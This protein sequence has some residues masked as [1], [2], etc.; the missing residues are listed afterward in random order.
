MFLEVLG[1]NLWRGMYV[2]DWD[3]IF[4]NISKWIMEAAWN[5]PRL[6][7]SISVS[8]FVTMSLHCTSSNICIYTQVKRIRS[9]TV[10]GCNRI[11]R[12]QWKLSCGCAAKIA[13]AP[14][15]WLYIMHHEQSWP[16]QQLIW[17]LACWAGTWRYRPFCP[18]LHFTYPSCTWAKVNKER[19]HKETKPQH[20]PNKN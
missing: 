10:V 15:Y 16:G 13:R 20:R 12:I 5:R 3:I 9:G 19:K 7:P 14:S 1:L 6:L 8:V 11:L 2:L 17:R 18:L 4:I